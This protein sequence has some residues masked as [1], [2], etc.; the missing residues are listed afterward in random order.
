MTRNTAAAAAAWLT[1]KPPAVYQKFAGC[2]PF[3]PNPGAGFVMGIRMQIPTEKPF[4]LEPFQ[5]E[6]RDVSS[7]RSLV[8][9]GIH[10]DTREK[11]THDV[12]IAIPI[13]FLQ[14]A[15]LK[16][17]ADGLR[18]AMVLR[19]LD[20]WI[21][22]EFHHA[23]QNP[24]VPDLNLTVLYGPVAGLTLSY[25]SSRPIKYIAIRSPPPPPPPP[26]DMSGIDLLIQA[27]EQLAQKS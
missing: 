6:V 21:L 22:L 12:I 3:T 11:D 8:V 20:D 15:N 17:T 26:P 23:V 2:V 18:V 7:S 13:R 4:G 1:G 10:V 27:A 14:A 5:I 25:T 19:V 24:T 9:Y 16:H